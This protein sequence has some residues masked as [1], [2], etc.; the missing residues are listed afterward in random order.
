MSINKN[1]KS[2]KTY[3]TLEIPEHLP[4]DLLGD[5]QLLQVRSMLVPNPKERCDDVNLGP[6]LG[7]HVP[8][9]KSEI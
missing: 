7:G 1:K 8:R 3:L 6:R 5:H 9:A 2:K 4:T